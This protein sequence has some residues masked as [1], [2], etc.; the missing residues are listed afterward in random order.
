VDPCEEP[1]GVSHTY[2]KLLT[3][4]V[5]LGGECVIPVP[6]RPERASDRYSLPLAV[7]KASLLLYPGIPL[8]VPSA[9]YAFVRAS[10]PQ[11]P[12]CA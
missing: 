1:V 2:H 6:P 7:V 3:R 4:A 10:L 11:F 9:C 5:Q 8:S 12:T